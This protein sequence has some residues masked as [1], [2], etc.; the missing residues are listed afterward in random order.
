MN[1]STPEISVI[2]PFYNVEKFMT[3]SL[4]SLKNQTFKNFEAICVND[5]STDKTKEILEKYTSEDSRFKVINQN[6]QGVSA[7]RNT[8]LNAATGNYLVFFDPDDILHP[9]FLE[10]MLNCIKQNDSNIAFCNFSRIKEDE[11]IT[12]FNKVSYP[13]QCT[14][15]KTPFENFITHKFPT[16]C[17]SLCDKIYKKEIFQNLRFQTNVKVAEDFIMMHSLLYQASNITFLNETLIFYRVRRGSL[18][19]SQFHEDSIY[20]GINTVRYL[21]NLFDDKPLPDKIRRIQNYRY[22]KMLCK[23]SIISPYK[24]TKNNK[25]FQYW[26]KYSS[27]L[28]QLQQE[29]IYRPQYL[30]IRNSLFSCLFIRKKFKLLNFL[31][32]II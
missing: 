21:I 31:L 26:E 16:P 28:A 3:A 2:I 32:K 13:L 19:H 18:T 9:D 29:G 23:D 1:Q 5:G 14:I 25:H 6:N 12:A 8:A 22:A 10:V 17:P 4:D 15:V 24:K 20:N 30:D 27:I 7:A 11:S